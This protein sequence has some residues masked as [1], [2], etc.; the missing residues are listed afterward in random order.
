[1]RIVGSDDGRR[2]EPVLQE[3]SEVFDGAGVGIVAGNDAEIKYQAPEHGLELIMLLEGM[4]HTRRDDNYIPFSYKIGLEIN[5][6]FIFSEIVYYDL[7]FVMPMHREGG[8]EVRQYGFAY[9]KREKEVSL[10]P[11]FLQAQ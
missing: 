7:H 2:N 4:K 8:V 6:L 1:M 5:S 11:G 3:G 10:L 9:Y